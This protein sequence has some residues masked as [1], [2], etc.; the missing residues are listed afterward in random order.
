[1]IWRFPAFLRGQEEERCPE[2]IRERGEETKKK[3]SLLLAKTF[4]S[5]LPSSAERNQ[6]L[7]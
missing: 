5:D 1:M 2:L 3:S 7:P 6:K 4:S